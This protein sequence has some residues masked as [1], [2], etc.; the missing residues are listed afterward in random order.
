MTAVLIWKVRSL[1]HGLSTYNSLLLLWSLFSWPLLEPCICN[2]KTVKVIEA[3]ICRDMVLISAGIKLNLILKLIGPGKRPD[4]W[5]SYF[6]CCH[7]AW[8]MQCWVEG[9]YQTGILT[10]NCL[11]TTSCLPWL[12]IS[13][14]GSLLLGP[15]VTLSSHINS[16]R[17]HS[18]CSSIYN[19]DTTSL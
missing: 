12:L 13:P 7:Q 19:Q 10:Y 14:V 5:S 1:K 9:H 18:L 8:I 3:N 2:R 15:A 4:E 11:P 17:P 6:C 16:W